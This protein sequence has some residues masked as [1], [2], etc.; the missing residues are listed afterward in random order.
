MYSRERRPSITP[1]KHVDSGP[2]SPANVGLLAAI[3][4][5]AWPAGCDQPSK[6][7][8]S[9]SQGTV[10]DKVN[11]YERSASPA[12]TAVSSPGKGKQEDFGVAQPLVLN[13]PPQQSPS[14]SSVYG[15]RNQ[16]A[17][18]A[19]STSNTSQKEKKIPQVSPS[20]HVL[21]KI[22]AAHGVSRQDKV[23]AATLYAALLKNG[24]SP[25]K[26]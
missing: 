12:K 24:L 3:S 13:V 22:R 18:G 11:R 15:T 7:F 5:E 1:N 10:K 21:R 14:A 25:E 17:G 4:G 23:N 16:L 8:G 6:P 19:G 26:R 9:P 2:P 20:A